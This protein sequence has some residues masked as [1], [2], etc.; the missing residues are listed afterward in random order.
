MHL[1]TKFQFNRTMNTEAFLPAHC[2]LLRFYE[3]VNKIVYSIFKL[4]NSIFKLDVLQVSNNLSSLSTLPMP[5]IDGQAVFPARFMQLTVFPMS[6]N[7][8]ART[9]RE[10]ALTSSI[11]HKS[12]GVRSYSCALNFSHGQIDWTVWRTYVLYVR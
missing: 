3:R 7:L 4:I 2:Q 11:D 8:I 9:S 12:F 1:C 6:I 10:Q 5:Y